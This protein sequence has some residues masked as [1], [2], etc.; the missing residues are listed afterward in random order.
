MI[1][2]F[3]GAG[4]RPGSPFA[5]KTWT[6]T[7]S[8]QS[9][10]GVG[11]DCS[12]GCL[13]FIKR[14]SGTATSWCMASTTALMGA[15]KHI[16]TDVDSSLDTDAQAVTSFGTSGITVGTSSLTNASGAS[17]VGYFF[18]L[19]SATTFACDSGTANIAYDSDGKWAVIDFD[20]ATGSSSASITLTIPSAARGTGV[21]FVAVF[22]ADNNDPVLCKH[23]S[24]TSG[25]FF[26]LNGS[27]AETNS[28]AANKFGNN[29]SAV[30]P[31]NSAIVLGN[32]AWVGSQTNQ[33]ILLVFYESDYC[34][35]FTGEHTTGTDTDVA[36]T[37]SS[38]TP[39]AA[40]Y[41]NIDLNE[42]WNIIDEDRGTSESSTS[43]IR[44]DTNA[45]AIS[46]DYG[47]LES[48]GIEIG[49]SLGDGSARTY[50]GMAFG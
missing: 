17:Y 10:S 28:A 24:S 42:S 1:P 35:L 13:V 26:Y 47:L 20:R 33:L 39:K 21:P 25:Y 11:F 37:V 16:A 2:G 34:D 45:S 29:S 43:L 22:D 9:I 4:G 46:G 31:T 44:I 8:S 50:V 40:W 49:A 19:D 15:G 48:G 23:P 7:G 18:R 14:Y 41:K 5:I 36:V 6:G 3:I 38:G 30:D 27:E 12:A 32:D